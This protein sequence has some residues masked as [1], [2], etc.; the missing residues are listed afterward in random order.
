MELTEQL[1]KDG[2]DKGLCRLWQMK[3]KA[4]LTT[5][6]LVGLYIKGIDFCISNDYPT[7][8]FLRAQFT[9][10]CEPFGV[11]VDDDVPPL[12]NEPNIVLNGKCRAMLEYNG[13][14]VSNLFV[15]HDSE[16]AVC[17]SDHAVAT[18]DLFDNAR[19][20]LSIADSDAKVVVNIHG[21]SATF[22]YVGGEKP[23]NL[24][25]IYNNKTTY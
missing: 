2:I 23:D 25:L 3:L 14:S 7:L 16:C 9:G 15:R 24:K 10:K 13:Y 8:D 19:L 11:F 22:D 21:A 6:E 18:I 20:H 1:K 4:G 17:V 12:E 5:K